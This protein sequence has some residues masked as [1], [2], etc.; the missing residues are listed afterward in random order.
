MVGDIRRDIDIHYT[1]D[2]RSHPARS[3]DEIRTAL[4]ID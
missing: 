2:H 4:W 3:A 1:N